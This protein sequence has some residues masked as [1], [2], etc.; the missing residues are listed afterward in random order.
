MDNRDLLNLGADALQRGKT[1][2]EED[3]RS[4][5]FNIADAWFALARERRASEGNTDR[6]ETPAASAR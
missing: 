5:W 6:G 4:L 2:P 3:L 1:T